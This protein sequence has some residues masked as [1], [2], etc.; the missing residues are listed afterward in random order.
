MKGTVSLTHASASALESPG[1]RIFGAIIVLHNYIVYNADATNAFAEA[2][3]PV[4]LPSAT[5]DK[6]YNE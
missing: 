3:L 5:T 6:Q 4:A 2:L 1:A